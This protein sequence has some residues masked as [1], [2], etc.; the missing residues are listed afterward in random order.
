MKDIIS[1]IDTWLENGREFA[2]ARVIGTW[3]S[4]PRPVGSAMIIDSENNMAGSV[5]GGCV[6]KSV[7]VAAKEVMKTKL[8]MKKTYGVSNDMAWE[9]GLSCGGKVE[10]LIEPFN[11]TG[12]KTDF[13]KLW[14]TFKRNITEDIGQGLITDI[15]NG[16][17]QLISKNNIPD[18]TD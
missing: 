16:G 4:S 10:V 5:S 15:G 1:T 18:K 2:I 17:I 14:D 6:E 9:V 3:R 11:L 8:P 12:L 7:I 13:V